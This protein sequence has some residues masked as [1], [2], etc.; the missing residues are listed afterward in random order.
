MAWAGGHLEEGGAAGESR[1]ERRRL[2]A[3]RRQLGRGGA[4]ARVPPRDHAFHP[5]HLT[6]RLTPVLYVHLHRGHLFESRDR[7]S[8]RSRTSFCTPLWEMSNAPRET[9]GVPVAYPRRTVPALSADDEAS[10]HSR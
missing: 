6:P 9:N 7:T 2:A 8:F 4:H 10:R 3:V 1:G 5:G